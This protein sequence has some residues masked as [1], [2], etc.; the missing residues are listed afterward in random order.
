MGRMLEVYKAGFI[1]PYLE[2]AYSISYQA[3]WPHLENNRVFPCAQEEGNETEFGYPMV[4]CLPQELSLVPP[5][6]IFITK[7]E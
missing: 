6:L 7:G 4:Q 3:T 5:S 1:G 2:T